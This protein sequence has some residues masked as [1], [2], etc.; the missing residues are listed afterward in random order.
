MHESTVSTAPSAN[1]FADLLA[2]LATAQKQR[3]P[4]AWNDDDLA[5]DVATISYEQALRA[6]SGRNF[7]GDARTSRIRDDG[8]KTRNRIVAH[9]ESRR[10]SPPAA[11]SS[12]PVSSAQHSQRCKPPRAQSS[13]IEEG[14]KAASI[15]VRLSVQDVD[16]LRERAAEAGLTTSAYLRS[17]IFEAETLRAEVKEALSQ[18]RSS[19]VAE[20]KKRGTPSV[21]A[22]SH[23]PARLLNCWPLRTRRSEDIAG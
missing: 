5:D 16:Q 10:L 3:G 14:R 18:L 19:A 7:D 13:C 17:C 8:A 4:Q 11:E 1:T 12:E 2:G 23:W 21:A 9:Q 15:T 20:R 22:T 6:Q